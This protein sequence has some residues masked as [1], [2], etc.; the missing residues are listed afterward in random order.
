MR[1][2][3][4]QIDRT[5][6]RERYKTY[7]VGHYLSLHVTVVSVVLAAAG[8]A[9]A[10]LVAQ[11]IGRDHQLWILWVLWLGSLAATAVAYGGPMVGAF[12]LPAAIPS[13]ADLLLPLLVGISEFLLFTILISQVTRTEIN[14]IGTWIDQTAKSWLV[15]ASIFCLVASLSVF[16]ARHHYAMGVH[17]KIYSQEVAEIIQQYIKHLTFDAYAAGGIAAIAAI[18]AGVTISDAVTLP[19]WVF[20]VIITVLL[21]IGLCAHTAVVRMWQEHFSNGQPALEE[22]LAV[23]PSETKE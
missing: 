10:S 19:T 15:I 2:L 9:A 20:P 22:R 11:P 12:A 6:L 4:A 8:L 7:L 1:S 14:V 16:R 18:G 23:N 3:D 13:I 21:L 17:E 5:E